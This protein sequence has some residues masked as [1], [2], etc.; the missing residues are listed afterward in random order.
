MVASDE[1][2]V[3]L[4]ELYC[5][6]SRKNVPTDVHVLSDFWYWIGQGTKWT[7]KRKPASGDKGCSNEWPASNGWPVERENDWQRSLVCVISLY[8]VRYECGIIARMLFVA[9]KHAMEK[10]NKGVQRRTDGRKGLH[11]KANDR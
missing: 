7:R 11:G 9:L 4:F 1:G 3:C 5:V 8:I 2:L 6:V 10:E